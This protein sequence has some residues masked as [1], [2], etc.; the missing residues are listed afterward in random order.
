[1]IRF[2]LIFLLLG[3][4]AGFLLSLP[5]GLFREV[6]Y[7]ETIRLAL[8]GAGLGLVLG[9]LRSIVVGLQKSKNR[10]STRGD[11][12]DEFDGSTKMKSNGGLK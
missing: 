3:A 11:E 5:S 1:M 7:F 6:W 2:V 4:T 8:V 12:L 10:D 9:V